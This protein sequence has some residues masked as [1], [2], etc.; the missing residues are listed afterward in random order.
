[1]RTGGRMSSDEQT[2]DRGTVLN[3][4]VRAQMERVTKTQRNRVVPVHSMRPLHEVASLDTTVEPMDSSGFLSISALNPDLNNDGVVEPWEQEVYQ[5]LLTADADGSGTVS[6]KEL[7][8]VMRATTD[9]LRAAR[10]GGIPISDLDPDTNG[11]GRVEAWENDVFVRIKDA[12]EDQSGSISV[13]ELYAVIRRAAESDRQKRM[14]RKLFLV[15]A[16]GLVLMLVANMGLTAAVVFLAKDTT[17]DASGALVSVSSGDVVRV[18]CIESSLNEHM[19][20]CW[21]R[22]KATEMS[23]TP[24]VSGRSNYER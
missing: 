13:K 2:V 11:D 22:N 7:F 10:K 16:A 19:S 9:E 15:A 8:G 5:R 17:V 20:Y 4:A 23:A 1:M 6:V 12:D 14:F 24:A 18:Q 21:S 3:M